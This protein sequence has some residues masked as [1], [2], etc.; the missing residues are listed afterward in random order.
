MKPVDN[1]TTDTKLLVFSNDK[2]M[3]TD[4]RA[5][6][7]AGGIALKMSRSGVCAIACLSLLIAACGSTEED[8]GPAPQIPS[9]TQAVED[10]PSQGIEESSPSGNHSTANHSTATLPPVSCGDLPREPSEL[11]A[12]LLVEPGVFSGDNF[13]E[14]AALA[15]VLAQNPRTHDE[16]LN[17]IISQVQGDYSRAVCDVIR[18][19]AELGGPAERPTGRQAPDEA[20]PQGG[21]H[22]ALVLDASGSMAATSGLG[23]RMDAATNAMTTFASQLPDGATISLRVYGQEGGNSDGEKAVSCGSSEVIFQGAVGDVAFADLIATVK[24]VGWTPLARAISLVVEDIPAEAAGAVVYVVTDG[25][26]TCGGDP[27]AAASQLASVGIE[28]IINVV[29]FEVGDAE[30]AALLA[31][32]EAGNGQYVK[33]SSVRDLD[34]FWTQ[35]SDRLQQAWKDWREAEVAK[36]VAL[37]TEFGDKADAIVATIRT[38]A[39]TDFPHAQ[40]ISQRLER[41]GLLDVDERKSLDNS[42]KWYFSDV[43]TYAGNFDIDSGLALF[44]EGW[45]ESIS[46]RMSSF[47][48]WRES[49]LEQVDDDE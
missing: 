38:T 35:E 19:S 29:G 45:D 28:P 37:K 6:L 43:K 46:I 24:P 33:A 30:Q 1:S 34:D 23:T 48:A 8:P 13:D 18:F 11:E 17:A 22:F 32:A 49:Y 26:E 16:W 39:D 31:I 41:E 25:K 47:D 5:G 4:A 36:L 42:I 20:L 10:A 3:S 44:V 2:C 27:V 15:A 40:A 9:T 12:L 14:E 7:V 21:Q